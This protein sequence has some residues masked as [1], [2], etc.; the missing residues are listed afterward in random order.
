M[1]ISEKIAQIRKQPEHIRLRW[2]WGSVAVSM[3]FIITIWIFSITLI[4]K[5]GTAKNEKSTDTT[6]SLTEQ[7][8][9]AKNQIPSITSFSENTTPVVPIDSAVGTTR[10]S[11]L[12]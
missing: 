10:P 3:F 5:E 1:N 9:T 11:D 7:L 4:F 6:V 8:K 2:V 12:Q